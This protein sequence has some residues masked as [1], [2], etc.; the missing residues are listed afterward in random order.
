MSV[1]TRRAMLG[2]AALVPA[3]YLLARR[4]AS[5]P[6]THMIPAGGYGPSYFP[7][8]ALT[9]HEGKQVRFYDDLLA[10]RFVVLNFMYTVCEGIC[11]GI[12]HNLRG[13]QEVLGDRVGRDVFM[14]SLT[15]KPEE[16]D[17]A[18]LAKYVKENKIGPGW[19][20]L[21]GSK[22]NLERIRI[23]LGFTDPDPKLD[24][25]RSQHTGMVKFGDVD[26]Q[27]WAACPGK[28]N[29]EQIAAAI[30]NLIPANKRHG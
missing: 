30:V 28:L 1:W 4:G 27:R 6:K 22:A 20:F 19:Q 14:Y 29:P 26:M 2:A 24:A 13:A 8:V 16:D 21:T 12:T 5:Q 11:S 25:V 15:L 18:Q 23:R 9:T 3:G 17:P 10:G 7:N